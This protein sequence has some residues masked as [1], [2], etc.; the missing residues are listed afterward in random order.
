LQR[1]RTGLRAPKLGVRLEES[2]DVDRR[3]RPVVWPAN[4]WAHRLKAYRVKQ[5]SKQES[6]LL[7]PALE[8]FLEPN[9][10]L[11]DPGQGRRLEHGCP[12][13]FEICH[14]TTERLSLSLGGPESFSERSASSPLRQ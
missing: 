9:E 6:R 3:R 7:R 2:D 13:A 1:I 11:L 4:L 5:L 14:L 10:P 12:V 8:N